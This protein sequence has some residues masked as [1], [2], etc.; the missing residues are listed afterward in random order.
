MAL[1]PYCDYRVLDTTQI[2]PDCDADLS[3]L[4]Q[5]SEQP[6]CDFNHALASARSGDWMTA[7]SRLG[8]VLKARYNDVD[9]WL[10]LGLVYVR[11]GALAAARDCWWKVLRLKENH[12]GARH[13]LHQVEQL[14]AKSVTNS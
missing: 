3:A 13:Y 4:A 2:C 9:A 12:T 6:D 8:C 14:L 11:L 5:L 1:C 7:A 10:L